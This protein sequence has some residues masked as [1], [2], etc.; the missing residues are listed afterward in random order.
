MSTRTP[1]IPAEPRHPEGWPPHPR[2]KMNMTP[3]MLTLGA[4]AVFA[5][6]VFMVV[7][8]PTTTFDPP[9]SENWRPLTEAEEVGRN[10]YLADG[11][12]YCH[13]GFSRPQDV[14][15]GQYYVY[16][17]V[18]EPGDYR[19]EGETPNLFGT[20][21]T[22]PDLSNA[23]GFHPDDWHYAHYYNPRYVDPLS[24][25]PQFKFLDQGQML[26]LVAFTQSQGGK[27]ADI[28]SEHQQTMKAFYLASFSVKGGN[29]GSDSDGYPAAW[30]II[31]LTEIE[32]G[33]WFEQNPLP[34]TQE[35]LLDGRQI[36]QERCVGCHGIEG[37]GR[38]PAGP[39]LN[40][41]P[42]PFNNADHQKTGA[43]TSP[44][45]YYWRILRGL[46]GTAMENFGTRLSVEQIWSVVLFLKTIANGGLTADL[47]TTDMYIEWEGFDGLFTWGECYLPEAQAAQI[48]PLDEPPPGVGDVPGIVAEG[49]VNPVYSAARWM[50]ENNARPCGTPGYEQTSLQQILQY[51]EGQ[52]NGWGRQGADQVGGFYSTIEENMPPALL[53]KVWPDD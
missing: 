12:I 15:A 21:R 43:D 48:M 25:M 29:S 26:A 45:A 32:R 18:S 34:L 8:L 5:T 3:M 6:V 28:R 20:T 4:M 47:P 7:V 35:N 30:E 23:G 16:P 14:L 2:K 52:T 46:P 51:A 41:G 42:A 11:C 44:G 19:A 39:F 31:N 10:I 24:I 50:I 49:D 53:E 17:R 27:A 13:S 40:P 1:E 36:F 22:G 38:G 33:Y 37:D 9:P